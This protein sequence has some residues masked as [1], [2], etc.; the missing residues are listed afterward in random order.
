MPEAKKPRSRMT[1]QSKSNIEAATAADLLPAEGGYRVRL[2]G[3]K[4]T[5]FV[6]NAEG[7]IV[8]SKMATAKKA[9]KQHNSNLSPSLAPTI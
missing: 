9:V 7:P 3:N 8:Y 2:T 5:A 4:G 1:A 6:E